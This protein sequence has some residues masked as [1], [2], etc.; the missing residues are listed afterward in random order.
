MDL[1]KGIHITT[2]LLSLGG[3]ILRYT[4]LALDSPRL[5]R[6]WVKISPHIN[7]TVLLISGILLAVRLQQFP[8][9]NSWLTAKLVALLVYIGLGMVTLRHGRNK[10]QRLLTG[11]AAIGVFTYML[12][13][14]V[15]HDAFW[16]F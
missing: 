2:V 1:L 5:H 13:I 4:W 9:V 15:T 14:A 16:L 11:L 12:G 8:F 7:D 10:T 6:R 3:F